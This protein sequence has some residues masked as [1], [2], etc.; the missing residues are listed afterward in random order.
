MKGL[1][2][3]NTGSWYQVLAENG[4][5]VDC[6][7]R[8]TFRLQGIRST[9]PIT[10]GDRVTIEVNKE[11]TAFILD[12][13]D[14]KNYIIRRSSNL[15]KQSHIIAAN[16]D[17]AILIATIDYPE[18]STVFIDRFLCSAEA[19][20]IPVVL[21]INKTDL[22]DDEQLEYMTGL[23]HLYE[24]IGYECLQI[25]AV[26][27]SGLSNLQA[28]LKGKI[29]LFSGNSGVGKSTLINALIPGTDLKTN[30]ISTYH[31]K[32]IHT[33]TFSEMIA[34]PDGG[35]V[36]D[37][38]G[39]KGFGSVDMKEFEFGH[40][41]REIFETS[42][43]CRFANCTHRREPGCAVLDAV[44]NQHISQSRYNSYLSIFNDIGENKY[45]V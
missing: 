27:L 24:H 14:R 6:K 31:N 36:I 2:I 13:E 3:K 17:Q 40:Y 15:S 29:S 8:G 45:R 39:I 22:Y 7:V 5:T 16:L 20:H 11:G 42:K 37:T 9:N 34:L 28:L 35:F 44:E 23:I 25:S 10:V 26:N 1:V 18:T 30:K 21:V 32:G 41:F 12:I 4:A 19:Y 33:T 38:P 43:N